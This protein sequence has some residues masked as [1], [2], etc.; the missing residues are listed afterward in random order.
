[1]KDGA[2]IVLYNPGIEDYKNIA[3]Y[4]DKIDITLIID[5]SSINHLDEIMKY[6]NI[7]NTRVIYEHHSEN[8]GLCKG[9]NV[10]LRKLYAEGCKWA[11]TMNSDSYFKNDAIDVFRDFVKHNYCEKIAI[12]SP[13][14]TFDRN[15]KDIYIGKKDIKRAM[16]SGNYLNLDAFF[17]LGGFYEELFVD[18]LDNDYCI[19]AKK[20]KYRI[21]E[22]GEA[23]MVH[24]PC[25][26]R[27]KKIFF[28]EIM[29]GYD[30]PK[31]YYG[32]A[33]SLAYLIKT[34]KTGYEIVFYFYK[35][36][37]ICFL[38]DNKKEFLNQ[39]W[40]GTKEGLKIPRMKQL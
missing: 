12:L 8:F 25:Q 29:Y 3:S 38:F 21:V 14:Y 31:R 10:G 39:Y 16:M 4:S 19:R 11:L 7:D 5:N 27:K 30:S 17:N 20:N 40:K 34:Y 18:G 13:V 2:V 35:L 9:M 22:C 24:M 6:I 33:R 36:F 26:T 32:H 23:L 28:K 1:M 37:K 15:I